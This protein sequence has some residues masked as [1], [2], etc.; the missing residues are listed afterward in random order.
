[1]LGLTAEGKVRHG[2]SHNHSIISSRDPAPRAAA[3]T[4]AGPV[5]AAPDLAL[6]LP[7]VKPAVKLLS[8]A[9]ALLA[10]SVTAAVAFLAVS[11]TVVTTVRVVLA[12]LPAVQWQ[13]QKR[14]QYKTQYC[15]AASGKVVR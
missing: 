15:C 11:P 6:P 10:A 2:L 14:E 3:M 5:A 7:P 1:M 13:Q 4:A 12:T 9:P 8:T